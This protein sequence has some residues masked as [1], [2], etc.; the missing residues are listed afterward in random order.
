MDLYCITLSMYLLLIRRKLICKLIIFINLFS[1][2]NY[3]SPNEPVHVLRSNQNE[4]IFG[5]P[6]NRIG[7]YA[8]VQPDCKYSSITKLRTETLK[9]VL[10]S[11]EVLP[12]N[13]MLLVGN[14]S[15]HISL[16]C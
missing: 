8:S 7:V 5:T 6:A 4:L 11:M 12:L 13:R 16:L 1:A 10:T 15:G 9:G 14:D 3:R 2:I